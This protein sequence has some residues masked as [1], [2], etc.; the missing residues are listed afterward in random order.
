VVYS[1]LEPDDTMAIA[2]LWQWKRERLKLRNHPMLISHADFEDKD[3]DLIF[4]KKRLIA[5]MMLSER[6]FHT[7]LRADDTYEELTHPLF[8]HHFQMR[9]KTLQS[10]A[11]TLSKFKGKYIDFY[12]LAPGH[13]NLGAIVQ[14]LK[15]IDCWPLQAKWRVNLYSGAFNMKG[16]FEAD[17]E[18]MSE[19]MEHSAQPLVDM[20]KFPFFGGKDSHRWA[21]SLTSFAT[22]DFAKLLTDTHPLL[23]A[24]MKSFND[25]FNVHLIEPQNRSLFRGSELTEAEKER[26]KVVSAHYLKGGPTGLK[27]YAQAL[28]E[29]EEIFDKVVGFKKNTLRAFADGGCDSPL[30]DQLVFLYEWLVTEHPEYMDD[31]PPGWWHYCN[32]KCFTY[33]SEELDTEKALSTPFKAIQPTLKSPKDESSLLDMRLAL[34]DTLLRCV[35]VNLLRDRVASIV[36]VLGSNSVVTKD[37]FKVIWTS[38]SGAGGVDM[39]TLWNTMVSCNIVQSD[40]STVDVKEFVSWALV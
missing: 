11:A 33:T 6:D 39:T 20:S 19:I 2:Q 18:A 32:K 26:F 1:D 36:D 31:K 8:D 38:I 22:P 24:A 3:K 34:Q 37:A 13:G 29:D 10:I 27:D 9:T 17:F 12:I 40:D 5:A 25:E 4:E 21:G 7:L 28:L 14:E 30:C 35:R 15:R 16:M 23:A